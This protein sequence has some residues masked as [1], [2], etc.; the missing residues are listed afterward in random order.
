MPDESDNYRAVINELGGSYYAPKMGMFYEKKGQFS[1]TSERMDIPVQ[2]L[3]FPA[4]TNTPQSFAYPVWDIEPDRFMFNFMG[5]TG[6]FF[7][8]FDKGWVVECDK[9]VKVFFDIKNTD[10]Y[11]RV[12]DDLQCGAATLSANVR[13]CRS[14]AINN[15]LI[16]DEYGN[17]YHFGGK[18]KQEAIEYS[19]GFFN[20]HNS[21][22]T[23]S[24]WHLTKIEYVDGRTAE[25]AYEKKNYVV[26][27]GIS[28]TYCTYFYQDL[29]NPNS[30][31]E[32]VEVYNGSV[33]DGASGNGFKDRECDFV[34]GSLIIP[35][36]LK[37]IKFG[38]YNVEFDT[39]ESYELQYPMRAIC[40][41]HFKPSKTYDWESLTYL[42]RARVDESAVSS[43]DN[44]ALDRLKWHKLTSIRINNNLG[45]RVRQFKLHYN[46]EE[47]ANHGKVRL[48]L[49]TVEEVGAGKYTFEYDH[50]EQ[51]PDYCSYNIDHWG[52]YKETGIAERKEADYN[53]HSV[54]RTSIKYGMYKGKRDPDASK[55]T[56]GS[57]MK[58]TYPTGGYTRF[59]YE[60]HSYSYTVKTDKTGLD[61]EFVPRQAGG[62]R[63]KSIYNSDTGDATGEYVYKHY[64]YRDVIN[65]AE[66]ATSGILLHPVVYSYV[67]GTHNPNQVHTTYNAQGVRPLGLHADGCHV[68]YSCVSEIL[69]DGAA[70]V[71]RFTD[72]HMYPDN[73]LMPNPA[74]NRLQYYIPVCSK[75]SLRGL[76]LSKRCYS[77]S[78]ELAKATHYAYSPDYATTIRAQ[79][80]ITT[81][82]KTGRLYD[83][84]PMHIHT[85]VNLPVTVK[86]TTF[87]S[88]GVYRS[89]NTDIVYGNYRMTREVMNNYS[90]GVSEKQS[91]RYVFDEYVNIPVC[92]AMT[93]AYMYAYPIKERKEVTESGTT[94]LVEETKYAY[95]DSCNGLPATIDRRT[96]EDGTPISTELAY[97]AFGTLTSETDKDSKR[98]TVYV[99]GYNH[100]H[101]VA[102]IQNAD[103]AQVEAKIG[104][105]DAIGQAGTPDF[106]KLEALRTQLTFADVYIYKYKPGVGMS[107]C[108]LPDGNRVCYHYDL[109]GRLSHTTDRN[110]D[111]LDIY[112]YHYKQ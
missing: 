28:D 12:F 22:I 26:E 84:Y 33:I 101:I 89:V 34:D 93:D 46:D 63:I 56:I 1:N 76:M 103:T 112:D 72:Y 68:A 111:I 97:G 29:V 64:E 83:V 20:Q 6:S 13:N 61:K 107:E 23:A 25:F 37:C 92:K 96:Q 18:D 14:V 88:D 21:E 65:D 16:V 62:I 52:F 47:E 94:K 36:Y 86:D 35:S 10:N 77:G 53:R 48:C 2:N 17:K 71:Y 81:P 38:E 105:L 70:T 80:L 4:F 8:T 30:H 75:A 19:V 58:I 24:A 110:G 59:E 90:D 45:E 66:N 7:Y 79:K 87:F 11:S 9:P 108:I 99:W 98:T 50:P 15:F 109:A 40:Y 57:L 44:F 78:G 69:P 95:T 91:Y 51:L 31:I 74:G 3:G 104:N 27:M 5:Y 39:E 85:K 106:G 67:N 102:M 55:G 100:Q 32:H 60:P 82:Y 54:T 73:V 42:Q 41:M 49:E 43:A